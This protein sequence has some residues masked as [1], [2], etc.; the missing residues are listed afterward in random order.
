MSATINNN[1]N[2]YQRIIDASDEI[3]TENTGMNDIPEETENPVNEEDNTGE[4]S[5]V[6]QSDSTDVIDTVFETASSPC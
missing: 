4:E 6:N 1:Q 3:T 2:P 5:A